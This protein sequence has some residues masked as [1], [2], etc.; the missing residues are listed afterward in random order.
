M[1]GMSTLRALI[2]IS[3]SSTVTPIVHAETEGFAYQCESGL[4]LW[5]RP[6]VDAPP[7]WIKDEESGA[8]FRFN[9]FARK[10]ESFTEADASLY[11]LSVYRKNASPTLAQHI[12]AHR[13]KHLRENP[14]S[15]VSAGA[16]LQ[17]A[18]GK[19]LATHTF[20]P[21]PTDKEWQTAAFDEEGDYYLVFALSARTKQAH[22]R[23]LK[24]LA[25]LVLGYS[26]SPK[27]Q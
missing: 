18:D 12:N 4:C 27:K 7:G 13:A 10:G 9:A 6:I 11:A 19:R 16:V 22:E 15:K 5:R 26:K 14:G 21:G 24:D 3:L 23:A 20:T 25:N 1:S 2:M 8:R 17:N